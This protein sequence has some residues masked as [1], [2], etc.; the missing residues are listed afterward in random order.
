[1]IKF[2]KRSNVIGTLV[3]YLRD[4]DGR[5][6]EVR[7]FP[8]KGYTCDL[9]GEKLVGESTDALVGL[10]MEQLDVKRKRN[11]IDVIYLDINN[12]ITDS[13]PPRYGMDISYSL[14]H[15]AQV[16]DGRWVQAIGWQPD[17]EIKRESGNYLSIPE[18][19]TFPY[20][21]KLENWCRD[22]YQLV[23]RY[24]DVYITK[25]KQFQLEMNERGQSFID[26]MM[27]VKR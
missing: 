20:K 3:G 5:K 1:L 17:V 24:N 6:V 27:G 15:I 8:E 16:K 14:G 2:E 9:K 23:L 4:D 12:R 26:E 21:R 11:W 18:D 7:H 13:C 25:I 22:E 10:Y 19:A